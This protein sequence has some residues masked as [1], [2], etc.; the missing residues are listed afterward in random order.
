[1]NPKPTLGVG[2]SL[3]S[4]N[5]PSLN[6]KSLIR[7][8]YKCFS[9]HYKCIKINKFE[10]QSPADVPWGSNRWTLRRNHC[11]NQH[12]LIKF[13]MNGFHST[14]NELEL[15]NLNFDHPYPL[16][17][18]GYI[19]GLLKWTIAHL[20]HSIVLNE[21]VSIE[22]GAFFSLTPLCRG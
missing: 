18:R 3:D 14:L 9:K 13:G 6:I 21:W 22:S 16:W 12:V 11:W 8:R 17:G 4:E 7:N 20:E 19:A 5:E 1:M 15:S 2:T 10:L